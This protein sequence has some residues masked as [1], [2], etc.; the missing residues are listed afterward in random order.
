M[1]L[2]KTIGE[3]PSFKK[4]LTRATA[5]IIFLSLL[6]Q[7]IWA[8]RAM[9]SSLDRSLSSPSRVQSPLGVT[10][11]L[12]M[13]SPIKSK[14]DWRPI[15]S[16][17]ASAVSSPRPARFRRVAAAA[18]GLEASER[19]KARTD[20]QRTRCRKRFV[21]FLSVTVWRGY[22]RAFSTKCLYSGAS[23]WIPRPQRAGPSPFTDHRPFEFS[24]TAK[25]LHDHP[26][27]NSVSTK[28]SKH[29]GRMLSTRLIH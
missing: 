24:K 15:S 27:R 21:S 3:Y 9:A 25:H 23:V 19:S 20:H 17:S 22:L 11:S 8:S 16:I 6:P 28:A 13:A 26:I 14:T 7:S 2:Q 18:A 29:V 12:S 5:L 4:A 1:N 10:S